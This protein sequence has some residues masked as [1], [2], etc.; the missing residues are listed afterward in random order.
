MMLKT[1]E[2]KCVFSKKRKKDDYKSSI[3]PPFIKEYYDYWKI[4]DCR[5][6]NVFRWK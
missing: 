2:E 5:Q 6:I 3:N 1:N 4:E